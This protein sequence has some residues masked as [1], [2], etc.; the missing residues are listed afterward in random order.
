MREHLNALLKT[1]A[2]GSD[3]SYLTCSNEWAHL[4]SPVQ[5]QCTFLF[6]VMSPPVFLGLLSFLCIATAPLCSLEYINK[7]S[8][9]LQTLETIS[10]LC[11]VGLFALCTFFLPIL[12]CVGQYLLWLQTALPWQP[13]LHGCCMQD[14]GFLH[15]SYYPGNWF[16][17]LSH[18]VVGSTP[19][20]MLVPSLL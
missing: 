13:S 4:A 17:S 8:H 1:W 6:P 14:S 19:M 11:K 9:T 3:I 16:G 7:S 10:E 20:C 18:T 5:K 2:L 15:N 12:G